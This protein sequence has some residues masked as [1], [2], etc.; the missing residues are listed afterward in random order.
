MGNDNLPFVHGFLYYAEHKNVK[1]LI[2]PEN[3]A[4]FEAACKVD[5]ADLTITGGVGKIAITELKGK[6]DGELVNPDADGQ[7]DKHMLNFNL[8]GTKAQNL[9]FARMTNNAKMVFF[10]VEKSGRIRALGN[11]KFPALKSAQPNTSGDDS[12]KNGV[13]QTWESYGE[14]PALIVDG[15][16]ANFEDINAPSGSAS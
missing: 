14:G 8:A 2:Y 4:T 15:T 9:G 13:D 5:F 3:P 6:I 1:G 11:D 16:V 7:F 10:V 12:T